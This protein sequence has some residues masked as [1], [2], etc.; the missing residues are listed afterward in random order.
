MEEDFG[1]NKPKIAVLGLNPHAGE[2]GL[3]GE[4]EEKNHQTCNQRT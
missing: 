2:D 4:E 1:I 3:L